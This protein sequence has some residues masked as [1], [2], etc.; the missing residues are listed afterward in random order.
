MI[1]QVSLVIGF[2]I[3]AGRLFLKDKSGQNVGV[4]GGRWVL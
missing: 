3:E 4:S 1:E 2:V